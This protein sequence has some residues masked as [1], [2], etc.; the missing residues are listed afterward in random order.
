MMIVID[1][2]IKSLIYNSLYLNQFGDP[3]CFTFCSHPCIDNIGEFLAGVH[4][5]LEFGGFSDSIQKVLLCISTLWGY[6][7]D[8]SSFM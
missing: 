3:I 6:D 5:D 4:F 2:L 1:S 7:I 8:Y